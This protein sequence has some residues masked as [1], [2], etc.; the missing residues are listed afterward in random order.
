MPVGEGADSG[1]GV[2]S[3]DGAAPAAT[4]G[5]GSSFCGEQDSGSSFCGDPGRCRGGSN[6]RRCDRPTDCCVLAPARR[7]LPG[8]NAVRCPS[9]LLERPSWMR[10]GQLLLVNARV[11]AASRSLLPLQV[12]GG[13]VVIVRRPTAIGSAEKSS[14]LEGT[15][16]QLPVTVTFVTT[17]VAVRK[18]FWSG[19]VQDVLPRRGLSHRKSMCSGAEVDQSLR[20]EPQPAA[21]GFAGKPRW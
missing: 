2:S 16:A 4:S 21:D 13:V 9:L 15:D 14:S 1:E 6:R 12:S 19:E 20:G 5:S 8:A 11:H 17:I 18:R 3:G 10:K 7:P